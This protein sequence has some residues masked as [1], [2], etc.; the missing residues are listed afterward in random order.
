MSTLT[1]FVL[2]RSTRLALPILTFPGAAFTGATVHELVTDPAAQVAAQVALRERFSTPALLSCMDLSVEAEA[3][4]CAINLAAEEVPTVLGRLVTDET[5]VKAL[6]VPAVGAG[7]TDVYLETVRRLAALPG[8]TPV[9]A[10]MI[11]PFSLAA[12]IY[13]VGEALG[14]SLDDPELTHR[15]LGKT[16]Q[17]LIAYAR[18]FKTAGATGVI[19]AEPTAGLLSPRALAEFSSAYVKQIVAAVD[20]DTFTVVLHNCAARLVHLPAVLTAGARVFHFGAPMNLPAALAQVPAD[21]ILCGNL[22]PAGVF[23]QSNPAAVREA[24]RGL[25][26]ATR[27]H[28]NFVLSSGCDVPPKTPLANLDAFF[29][30]LKTD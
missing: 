30:A 22:D 24:V 17:F 9:L 12:R 19:M 6:P 20:D 10:G 13:G 23:V 26:A 25:V 7:R 21:V 1:R 3:F 29:Q 27:A 8:Q 18:A 2:E 4:G 28:R 14:L 15:L 5:G 11:G 16:N